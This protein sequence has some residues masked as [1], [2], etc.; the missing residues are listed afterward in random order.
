MVFTTQAR[1]RPLG[2][3]RRSGRPCRTA[4][5][6]HALTRPRRA[7][8]HPGGARSVWPYPDHERSLG[9]ARYPPL[10]ECLSNLALHT[11]CG[12]S[13]RVSNWNRTCAEAAATL[14][15]P[16]RTLGSLDQD[17]GEY[18]REY[19]FGSGTHCFIREPRTFQTSC[20]AGLSCT[21]SGECVGG[22]RAAP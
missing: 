11:Y 18:H 17:T 12:V 5:A 14:G 16:A 9:V 4:R 2:L 20:P 8:C 13:Q 22:L 21:S 19:D 7:L 10:A 3:P 1:P 6:H 15:L